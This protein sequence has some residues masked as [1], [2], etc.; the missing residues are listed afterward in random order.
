MLMMEEGP[1][2][3]TE[4]SMFD[5]MV[6]IGGTI[7]VLILLFGVPLG[8]K[9]A[10][11]QK[12]QFFVKID[13]GGGFR[14]KFRVFRYVIDRFFSTEGASYSRLRLQPHGK[15]DF[16]DDKK[17]I[18]EIVDYRIQHL[19]K[20]KGKKF[21]FEER[22]AMSA[23]VERSLFWGRKLTF[24]KN[25]VITVMTRIPESELE[26]PFICSDVHYTGISVYRTLF[27]R[28]HIRRADLDRKTIINELPP[29][30]WP[31][32]LKYYVIFPLG[33]VRY[34]QRL[35]LKRKFKVREDYPE[36]LL[37]RNLPNIIRYPVY[38]TIYI[39]KEKKNNEVVLTQKGPE[40]KTAIEIN[41]MIHLT[42]KYEDVSSE[43]FY[44]DEDEDG[45][46]IKRIKFREKAIED[47]LEVATW[48]EE[49]KA[50]HYAQEYRNMM[51]QETIYTQNQTIE[52]MDIETHKIIKTYADTNRKLKENAALLLR[53]NIISE[54]EWFNLFGF[55]DTEDQLLEIAL[56]KEDL[57]KKLLNKRASKT[58]KLLE[59]LGQEYE[60]LLERG[61]K[62][63]PE[64]G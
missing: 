21:S 12:E 9:F 56:K 63:E 41:E 48:P 22:E 46:P 64:E 54:E 61:I 10:Y 59:E 4:W 11:F 6:I 1:I 39:E 29:V 19:E 20:E 33:I 62:V 3:T 51:Q 23:K 49:Q 8:V 57:R 50:L 45:Q 15:S 44:S 27:L 24:D 7:L 25:K 40:W 53:K 30:L 17:E 28:C 13:I 32:K 31:T 43:M 55:A 26:T 42:D 5:Y 36:F 35:K 38:Q 34:I 2:S 58:E 47:W 14:Q 16:L 60:E 37:M 18:Q 52:E